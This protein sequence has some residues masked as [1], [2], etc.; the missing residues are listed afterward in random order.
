MVNSGLC[1]AS[2]P[3]LRK[4]RLSSK[5]L[6]DAAD[7]EPLEVQLRRDAQVQVDVVGVDVGDE[8]AGVGAAVDGLQH[9][10]LDLDEAALGEARRAARGPRPCAWRSIE[11]GL[12]VD[13]QVDVALPDPGLRVGQPASCR[14][15]ARRHLAVIAQRSAAIDSSPRRDGAT[16]PVTLT[17]SPRSTAAAT[18]RAAS[19]PVRASVSM[20][21]T[22]RPSPAARRTPRRRSRAAARTGRPPT[23]AAGIV[24]RERAPLWPARTVGRRGDPGRPR[25]GRPACPA[26]QRRRAWRA[27][28]APAR[29]AGALART[30]RSSSSPAAPR[31]PANGTPSRAVAVTVSSAARR[32]IGCLPGRKPSAMPAATTRPG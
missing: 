4:L 8:R 27:G 7:A 5:T 26:S 28:R 14:A 23:P 29:S 20:T 13:D 6:L 19:P 3:S 1:V 31:P 17:W 10:R 25:P 21:C 11:P 15:A 22:G 18:A 32:S 30:G 24:V 16:S 12:G 2:A 9:R